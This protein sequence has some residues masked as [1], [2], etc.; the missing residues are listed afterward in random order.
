MD[1]IWTINFKITAEIG[2]RKHVLRPTPYTKFVLDCQ[3]LGY[4]PE[5]YL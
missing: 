3:Y 2:K 4:F 5:I 1:V